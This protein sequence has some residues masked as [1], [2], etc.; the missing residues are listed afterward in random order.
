MS[1]HTEEKIDT[2]N[3][4][5]TGEEG[6]SGHKCKHRRCGGGRCRFGKIIFSVLAI[7]G[8]IWVAGAVFGPDCGQG[9]W[10]H[11]NHHWSESNITKRM[12]RLTDRLIDHVDASQE[13]GEQ[14]KSIVSSYVPR[15]QSMKSG[16]LD[17]RNAFTHLLTQ[18]EI[19]RG[20][21]ERVRQ[22]EFALLNQNSGELVQ[23]I[24]DIADVLTHDQRLKLAD[25]TAEF[26]HSH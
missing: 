9:G 15:L 19:D 25:E 26:H 3:N 18:P 6:E 13:Q 21:L 8:I 5:D 17:N 1:E 23:M 4:N 14:I 10:H 12:N 2:T 24:A 22:A 20:E 16:H 7:V 11:G